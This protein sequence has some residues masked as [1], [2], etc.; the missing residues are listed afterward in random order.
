MY[1]KVVTKHYCIYV[2]FKTKQGDD[3][4]SDFIDYSKSEF[5]NYFFSSDRKFRSCYYFLG[6]Y[7][8][9]GTTEHQT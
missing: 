5:E 8:L 9:F 3:D 2:R 7:R 1:S 6:L 4:C